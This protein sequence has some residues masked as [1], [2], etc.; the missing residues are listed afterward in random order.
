MGLLDWLR[1]ALGGGT[2]GEVPGVDDAIER[3]V[4]AAN[5]RLKLVS[6][7]KKR[8]APGVAA[9]LGHVSALVAAIPP[10][11]SAGV[12]DWSSDPRLSAFFANAQ[13]LARAFS[14]SREVRE[15][16]E[17]HP[18]ATETCA[19]LGMALTERRVLG[20]GL[21][22]EAVRADVPQTTLSFGDHRVRL[23]AGSEA[24]LRAELERRLLEQLAMEGLKRAAGDASRRDDLARDR[25]L[26]QARL[27]L[28]A[29]KGGGLQGALGGDAAGGD[30]RARIAAELEQNAQALAALGGTVLERELGHVCDILARPG[31]VLRVAA[32]KVV[33]DRMNVV[34]EA[35]A[36]GANELEFQVAAVEG[37]PA[38]ERAFA[39]VRF[40]RTDLLPPDH[41]LAEAERLLG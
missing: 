14:R 37:P 39:L 7:Y 22:G 24:G 36:N 40:P 16:F 29:R 34:Q 3:I 20:M 19:L 15:F 4:Q 13:D 35:G 1:G 6:R 21:Q 27:K 38:R 30:E 17:A 8:L 28:L 23:C 5:P 32:R 12:A 18:A 41:G 10:A 25:A 2:S 26:L 31:E 33:L 9:S 11:L